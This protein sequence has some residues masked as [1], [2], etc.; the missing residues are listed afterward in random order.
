[1]VFLFWAHGDSFDS[2]DAGGIIDLAIIWL[3]ADEPF[4]SLILVSQSRKDAAC[5]LHMKSGFHF[6]LWPLLYEDFINQLIVFAWQ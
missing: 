1:M 2:S 4:S 3:K 6:D 5:Q